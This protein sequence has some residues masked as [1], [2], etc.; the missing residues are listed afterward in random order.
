MG[1]AHRTITLPS[2]VTIAEAAALR[3]ELLPALEQGGEVHLDVS[4]LS[5]IDTAGVQLLLSLS[6][7]LAMQDRQ[8][9]ISGDTLLLRGELEL[10]GL[11]G[12]FELPEAES[13]G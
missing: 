12:E 2:V 10:L 3:D 1:G 7:T 13:A 8:L 6:N 11:T 9:I 4:A 5:R